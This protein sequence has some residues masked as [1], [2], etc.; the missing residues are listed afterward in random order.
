MVFPMDIS[1][2]LKNATKSKV[3]DKLQLIILIAFIVNGIVFT[4][5]Q[6]VV[7]PLGISPS[8]TIF[9]QAIVS[10]IIVIALTR[11]FVIRE[12]DK[13]LEHQKSKDTSLSSYYYIRDKENLETIE[14]APL[15]EY[16]D[17]NFCV[18]L[19]FAYG[20]NSEKKTLGNERFLTYLFK[21]SLK[22]NLHLRTF[23]IPENF[24][25]SKEC[26]TL[27]SKVSKV[28]QDSLRVV[29]ADLINHTL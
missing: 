11:V 12:D 16:T 8:T 22:Y 3:T 7:G 2:R 29:M 21:N 26:R 27:Q 24:T 23:N 28:E 5:I 25:D 17:G 18:I 6:A 9:V 15:F 20:A 14:T 13:L 1:S 10:V 4:Q 19:K